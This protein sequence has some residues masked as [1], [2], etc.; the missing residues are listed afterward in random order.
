MGNHGLEPGPHMGAFE[1]Q[2]A[3][4]RPVLEQMLVE[5]QGVDVEDKRFS[6]A[7]HYRRSRKKRLA[8]KAIHDAVTHAPHPMRI[9]PGKLV[10]NVL[11]VNAPH[12]GDALLQLRSEAGTD[13]AIYVGDDATDEDVFELDQPGRLLSIRVGPSY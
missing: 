11:P 7:I 1:H 10:V 13:T 6:L 3:E 12:K 9:I 4:V 5:H 2:M 8:R